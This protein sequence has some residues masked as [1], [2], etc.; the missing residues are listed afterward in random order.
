MG[1]GVV[2]WCESPNGPQGHRD[3]PCPAEEEPTEEKMER[4]IDERLLAR[5]WR[6]QWIEASR[7]E[8]T[9]GRRLQVVFP[10][11]ANG[12]SGPDFLGA[13]VALEDGRLLVGDVELHV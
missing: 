2:G 8:T 1:G 9:D 11:R 7:L 3:R 12:D 10:G 6:G 13:I 5:I 4:E